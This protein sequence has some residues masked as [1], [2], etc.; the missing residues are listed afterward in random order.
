MTFGSPKPAPDIQAVFNACSDTQRAGLVALRHLILARAA[1]LPNIGRVTEA[2]RWGQPAYLTPDTGAACS[3]RI[4]LAPGGD[5]ALFVHCKTG[6]IQN[7][8]D[9]PGAEMRVQGTRAVLF[10]TVQDIAAPAVSMLIGQAL[11]YHLVK[12]NPHKQ[13]RPEP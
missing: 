7:F 10:R 9:G 6:L 12:T 4:G 11:T 3:L 8:T 13:Q 2:L 1:E 5:F